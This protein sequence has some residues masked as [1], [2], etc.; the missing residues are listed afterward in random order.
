MTINERLAAIKKEGCVCGQSHNQVLP[1]LIAGNLVFPAFLKW[2]QSHRVGSIF[3]V[4]DKNTYEAAGRDLHKELLFNRFKLA[5]LVFEASPEPDESAVNHVLEHVPKDVSLLLFVGSG[6]LNDIGKMIAHECRLPY[7]IYATAPSMDGYTSSTASMLWKGR[8]VSLNAKAPDLVVAEYHVLQKAPKLTFQ[9]G[10]GDMAAKAVSIP[11]WKV[12]SLITGEPYCEAIASL[13]TSSLEDALTSVDKLMQREED[14]VRRLF[15]GLILSGYAMNLAGHSRPASG[16][17]HYVS[18]VW[19]MRAAALGKANDT[20][21]R[22][23][24]VGTLLTFKLFAAIEKLSPSLDK[25]K[26][27]IEAFDLIAYQDMLRDILGDAAEPLIELEKKEKKYEEN[28]VLKHTKQIVEHWSEIVSCYEQAGRL[29]PLVEKAFSVSDTP[30][31]VDD[32]TVPDPEPKTV[33]KATKDIRDKYVSTRLLFDIGEL[34]AV[35]DRLLPD[36]EMSGSR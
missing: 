9:S 11:E 2:L 33:L 27:H 12:A 14:A 23:C 25:A 8:K 36:Q 5:L 28:T 22:Q 29:R 4:A 10:I 13:V 17:E 31:T 16:T 6:T 1:E 30:Q 18:H 24:G 7:V 35:L 3:M 20:H 34:D 19:D 21:G 26:A 32:L 15:D